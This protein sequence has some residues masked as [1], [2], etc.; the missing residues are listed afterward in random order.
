M[1]SE[2]NT[3]NYNPHDPL[4]LYISTLSL[5]SVLINKCTFHLT[6]KIGTSLNFL[7]SMWGLYMPGENLMTGAGLSS[8]HGNI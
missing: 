6:L 2:I 5:G 3:E 1:E 4:T 8:H 7:L